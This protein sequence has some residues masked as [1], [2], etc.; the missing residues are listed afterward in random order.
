MPVIGQRTFILDP[1]VDKFVS[2]A[3]EEFTRQ[4]DLTGYGNSWSKMRIALQIAIADTGGGNITNSHLAVGLSNGTTFPYGSQSC[5]HFCGFVFGSSSNSTWTRNAG[6]GNPYY[7]VQSW[8]EI[9]KI[10]V[11]ETQAAI[12]SANFA[13]PV[14]TGSMQRRGWLATTM[15]QDATSITA[16]AYSESITVA[17]LDVWYEHFLYATGQ[18]GS[19]QVLETLPVAISNTI[20]PGAGWNTNVLNTLDIY[21]SNTTYPLEIYAIAIEFTA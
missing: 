1:T 14:N 4:I 3:G 17:V 9:R 18:Q 5:V 11:T 7:T 13:I 16:L 2:L 19:P 21:W 20:S 10:G 6:G 15:W 8:Y 12:G